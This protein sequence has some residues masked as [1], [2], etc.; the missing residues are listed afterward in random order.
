MAHVQVLTTAA[1]EAE[2]PSGPSKSMAA[3]KTQGTP[4]S[5]TNFSY[6]DPWVKM[7]VVFSYIFNRHC[8]Y[9]IY[10]EAKYELFDPDH[11]SACPHR[12]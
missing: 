4:P 6:L 7:E 2:W 5:P 12:R 1:S 10:K 9:I 8:Y 11:S 3:E